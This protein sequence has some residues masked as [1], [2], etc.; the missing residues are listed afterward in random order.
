MLHLR[1]DLTH[2]DVNLC[3]LLNRFR[4]LKLLKCRLDCLKL[5][6]YLCHDPADALVLVLD[7]PELVVGIALCFDDPAHL[8]LNLSDKDLCHLL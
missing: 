2:S 5:L 1:Y 7:N 6:V 3:R 4:S 8:V